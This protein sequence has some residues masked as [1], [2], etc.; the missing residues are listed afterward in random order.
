MTSPAPDQ[1]VRDEK[2]NPTARDE[3]STPDAHRPLRQLTRTLLSGVPDA[4]WRLALSLLLSFL[5]TAASVALMGVSAWLLSRAAEHPPVLYL[6]VAAVSVRALGISRGVF[7]YVERLVGHDVALR[8]QSALRLESYHRLARTT[9]LGSRRGDLLSRMIADVEAIQDLVVRVWIPFAGAS[10]VITATSTALAFFSPGAAAVLLG[11]SVLA[12][13]VV[14]LLARHASIAADAAAVPL[15][16]ELANAT[17]ELSRTAADL[18]AYGADTATLDAL[19]A[20]D[21]RLHRVEARAAWVRGVAAASQ[22]IAAGTSVVAALV[23]G[24][25]QVA[26][27]ALPPVMLAVLVL[28][29]L[30]LHEAMSTLTQAAQTYTRAKVA[31]GRVHDVLYAEPIGNGDVPGAAAAAS[32]PCLT[33]TDVAAGWPGQPSVVSGFSLTIRAGEK[34]ALVG[35]SGVG[36]TTLAATILGLIPARAGTIDVRGRLGYL[37]QDAHIFAT[38][39]A[40]NVRLGNP[41]ASDEEVA[42]ALHRSGLDLEP[43]RLLGELGSAVSGGEA[44]RIA[45]A[46]L[47]V[48]DYQVLILDE[49]SEHLDALTASALLDDMWAT[50]SERPVLVIT[51]DPAVIARCDRAVTLA[52]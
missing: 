39:I 29:P 28:T 32:D 25:D 4:T 21:A 46:R 5:A 8:L 50:T 17:H 34:V 11:S 26:S 49:P 14:P 2:P 6:Q 37:A 16:G 45:L 40:E 7:R 31:L 22:V 3:G 36:K 41:R 35:P 38:T 43:S 51:H 18:V 48:D 1:T 42:A 19:G 9:L 30:A 33:L 24:A 47:F 52:S 15:R 27:G 44:R 20:V 12:G 23:I 10:L 13:I